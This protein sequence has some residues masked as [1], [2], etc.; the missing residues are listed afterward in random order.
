MLKTMP[1]TKNTIA[2]LPTEADVLDF[3]QSSPSIVGK[4]EIARHFGVTGG[5]KIE[6]K[7]LLR[8]MEDDGKLLKRQRK[9]IDRSSLPPITVLEVIGIM[10]IQRIMD[11]EV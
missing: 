3:I 11:I 1:R 8:K 7:A 5:G 9:L 4:R 6:L 2:A 10:I